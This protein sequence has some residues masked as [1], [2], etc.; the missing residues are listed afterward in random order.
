MNVLYAYSIVYILSLK[1]QVDQL[2]ILCFKDTAMFG[3]D[4]LYNAEHMLLVFP[5]P[6][7]W[8]LYG[9]SCNCSMGYANKEV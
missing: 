2:L 4:V 1:D 8:I 5:H 7:I 6:T 3:H 9:K